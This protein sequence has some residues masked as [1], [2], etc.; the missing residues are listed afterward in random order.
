MDF[1]PEEIEGYSEQFSAVESDLLAEIN[2]FTNAKVLMPRMLAGHLQGRVLAMLSKMISPKHVVEVG[3]YTGY[4]ALCW[5]EGLADGGRVDTIEVNDEL[6]SVVEAFFAKSEYRENLHLHIGDAGDVIDSLQAPFDLV[7]LDADKRNYPNYLKQ[8]LP[9]VNVGGYIIADN[10]LWSG[11]VTSDPRNMDE[12]TAALH[13]YNELV[14][15]NPNL[16]NVLLPVRDGLMIARK[17]A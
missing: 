14:T 6:Q 9:K 10:V 15:D 12:E 2:R 13:E 3:T 5:A 16:D 4:S 17:I 11:K 8:V 1:L 7:F